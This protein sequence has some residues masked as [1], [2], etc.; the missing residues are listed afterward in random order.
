MPF[1]N[2]VDAVGVEYTINTANLVLLRDAKSVHEL[3]FMDGSKINL[4]PEEAVRVKGLLT[5]TPG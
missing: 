1:L 3:V 2:V 5:T 4:K